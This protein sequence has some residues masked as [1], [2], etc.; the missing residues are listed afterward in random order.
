[1]P[2]YSPAI[3]DIVTFKDY[4]GELVTGRVTY[5][6]EH[7]GR[8]TFD[9]HNGRWGYAHQIVELDSNTDK[10]FG[11]YVTRFTSPHAPGQRE[12]QRAFNLL[13]AMH[14]VL[15]ERVRLTRVDP[16]Y[17]DD[18]LPAFFEFIAAEWDAT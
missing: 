4:A 3:G 2:T 15:A 17:R 18:R 11:E 9:L 8:P 13:A 5:V 12:G 16:F 6:S 14:P 1:M 7:R 10:T